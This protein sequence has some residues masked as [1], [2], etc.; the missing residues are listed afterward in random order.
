MSSSSFNG[1]VNGKMFP[2]FETLEPFIKAKEAEATNLNCFYCND[3]QFVLNCRAPHRRTPLTIYRLQ[4]Q[5]RPDDYFVIIP[6]R[7]LLRHGWRPRN[8]QGLQDCRYCQF[9]HDT[10]NLF[11]VGPSMN[12][13]NDS[14]YGWDSVVMAHVRTGLPLVLHG[15]E[16]VR[17][18]CR[19][20]NL[21]AEIEV[22]C[23]DRSALSTR[24]FPS[25]YLALPEQEEIVDDRDF[26]RF[27]NSSAQNCR[28]F[29][30]L[31]SGRHG[32]PSKLLHINWNAQ[33]IKL[34]HSPR[35]L[36]IAPGAPEMLVYATLSHCWSETDPKF[37]RLLKANMRSWLRGIRINDLPLAVQDAVEVAYTNNIHYIWIESLCIT[38]DDEMDCQVQKPRIGAY[39]RDSSITIVAASSASPSD[40]FLF[41][42]RKDWITKKIEFTAPSG[43]TATIDLRRRYSRQPSPLDAIDES[44]YKSEV[45]S[46]RRVGPLY[47]HQRCY[48]EALLGTRVISFTSAAI[49]VHCRRHAHCTGRFTPR[50]QRTDVF[51]SLVCAYQDPAVVKKRRAKRAGTN[52]FDDMRYTAQSPED[53]AMWL[54]AVMQYTARDMAVSPKDKL[55][56]IAGLAS[57]TSMCQQ[58]SQYC[59]GLWM[60]NLH[61]ALLWEVRLRPG[62]TSATRITFPFSHQKAPTYSWASVDAGVHYPEP[63]NGIFMSEATVKAACTVNEESGALNDVE[64]GYLKLRGRVMRCQVSQTL[65]G[66]TVGA[67]GKLSIAHFHMKGERGAINTKQVPF[68]ADGSLL[69]IKNRKWSRN[70]S[71]NGAPCPNCSCC[72]TEKPKLV[73]E[74][75]SCSWRSVTY[76]ARNHCDF[77]RKSPKHGQKKISGTAYVLCLGW[78]T[79]ANFDPRLGSCEYNC[80]EGLVVTPS[81]RYLGAFERIGCIRNIPV[82]AYE[83]CQDLTLTLV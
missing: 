33:E 28:M 76:L 56:G 43:G 48:Q 22:F 55:S 2:S 52:C 11:F 9:L 49:D 62:Q 25:M 36:P 66:P 24:D 54:Q 74:P 8:D 5:G 38:Q 3:L 46:F 71:R 7:Y 65:S 59:S 78:R 18:D 15:Q 30:D 37:P 17:R 31:T 44:S 47:R 6:I 14:M 64:G 81:L 70:H 67:K 50:N 41:P 72:K 34:Q 45:N 83:E 68:V 12:W 29:P 1:L 32:I 60:D 63:W 73:S 58:R 77:R 16:V 61:E 53:T 39:F 13:I 21:R 69:M 40:S 27:M 10:L 79:K 20:M 42:L 35:G 82:E 26:T 80:F 51:G 23:H 75:I 4:I 19:W 57:M